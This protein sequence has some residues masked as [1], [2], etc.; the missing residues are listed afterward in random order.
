MPDFEDIERAN[1]CLL[2]LFVY[3]YAKH[4]RNN[5]LLDRLGDL[6][7]KFP[8][9]GREFEEMWLFLYHIRS[10]DSLP[11]NEWRAIKNK[12]IKFIKPEYSN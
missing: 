2:Y 10:K 11:P 9:E 1:D 4:F 3:L 8:E 7:A 6:A 5:A 12:G